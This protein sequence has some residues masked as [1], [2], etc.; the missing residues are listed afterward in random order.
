ME[1]TRPSVRLFNCLDR[2]FEQSALWSIREILEA[3]ENEL[4]K[5]KGFGRMSMDELKFILAL[6]GIPLERGMFD[7]YRG[8]SKEYVYKQY[9]IPRTAREK[10]EEFKEYKPFELAIVSYQLTPRIHRHSFS[11][12]LESFEVFIENQDRVKDILGR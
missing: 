7:D 5:I 12:Y 9:R 8:K 1:I 11:R 3:S 10:F 6:Q 2:Y 4:N